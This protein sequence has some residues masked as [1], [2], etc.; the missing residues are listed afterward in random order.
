M[1]KIRRAVPE[2]HIAISV[3]V[4]HTFEQNN[5][6]RLIEALRDSGQAV[7]ELVA[8]K[9]GKIVGHICF[10]TLM[11]PDDWW[12]LAPVCV[13]NGLQGQGIGGELIRYGLDQARQ[14]GAQAVVVVGDPR[15]Y[16]R[17]GFV[18]DGATAL[19]SP[20]PSQYTG[21]Y[22]IAPAAAS[23]EVALLYPPAFDAA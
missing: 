8:E 2:D 3:L 5:E 18:F 21:L 22:P 14:A 23:A 4:V 16:R 13:A 12:S 20:Y 7:L 15:Y 11:R 10:S 17:F 19:T 1:L 9:D 6:H